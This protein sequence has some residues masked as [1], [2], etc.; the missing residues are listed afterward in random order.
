M[1]SFSLPSPFFRRSPTPTTGLSRLSPFFHGTHP[2]SCSFS[3]LPFF[4]HSKRERRN[5]TLGA[6]MIISIVITIQ[7]FIHTNVPCILNTITIPATRHVAPLGTAGDCD[8]HSFHHRHQPQR[9]PPCSSFRD[10]GD[11]D[12]HSFH[13][14][15][16]PQ[17]HPCLSLVPLLSCSPAPLPFFP[18][19]RLPSLFR[20]LLCFT[21]H[22][23]NATRSSLFPARVSSL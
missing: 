12:D 1:C 6:S 20:P 7:L 22:A 11:C 15:H 10:G 16:Q 3:P 5:Q 21:R 17:R 13:H 9:H 4:K 14:Q 19:S 23:C 8:D 18:S 2:V